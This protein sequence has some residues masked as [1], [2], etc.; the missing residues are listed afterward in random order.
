[1]LIALSYS[2]KI[3]K[4]LFLAPFTF[5]ISFFCQLSMV[6]L[7]ADIPQPYEVFATNTTT[8]STT[9][10][11]DVF[12]SATNNQ[13]R[14]NIISNDTTR[15][16][17]YQDPIYGVKIEY[18]SYWNKTE[19]ANFVE[20]R[21]PIE[22]Y[23]RTNITNL[24]ALEIRI[25][26]LPPDLV[27]LE[28]YSRAKLISHRQF[29][30]FNLLG[31]NTTT[32]AADVPALKTVYTNTFPKTGEV[33]KTMEITA[34]KDNIGYDIRYFADPASDY[35]KYLPI[36]QKMISSFEFIGLTQNG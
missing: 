36:I 14:N 4:R 16:L 6:Y 28:Q 31:S 18:P 21:L 12:Q 5:A 33:L 23:N 26:I 32:I 29:G 20:F 19:G 7:Y 35:S 9:G 27:S 2:N 3:H 10:T 11:T 15:F 34:I 24:I 30:E 17:T 22:G 8:V 13:S 25:D 1:M